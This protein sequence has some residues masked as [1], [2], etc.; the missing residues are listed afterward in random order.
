MMCAQERVCVCLRERQ[1]DGVRDTHEGHSHSPGF[2]CLLGRGS[3]Q[4]KHSVLLAK[5]MN[6][7]LQERI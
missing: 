4:R 5:F 7:H 1:K 3:L 6:A 2:N